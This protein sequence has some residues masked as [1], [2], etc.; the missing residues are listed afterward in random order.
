M[1]FFSTSFVFVLCLWW[2]SLF[3]V[4]LFSYCHSLVSVFIF[5]IFICC[6]ILLLFLLGIFWP[7]M[8]SSISCWKAVAGRK[9]R[10]FSFSWSQALSQS[11]AAMHSRWICFVT[12]SLSALRW[13]VLRMLQICS[14]S[15]PYCRGRRSFS[16]ELYRLWPQ[17]WVSRSFCKIWKSWRILIILRFWLFSKFWSIGKFSGI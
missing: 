2:S 9:K 5:E 4:E 15:A 6:E 14:N 11:L 12:S 16:N 13:F 1:F 10:N 3:S 7:T 8:S 17:T